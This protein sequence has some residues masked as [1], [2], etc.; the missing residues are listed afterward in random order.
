[1][2]SLN[3]SAWKGG[4]TPVAIPGAVTFNPRF[5]RIATQRRRTMN[6]R[7]FASGIAL[8][9]VSITWVFGAFHYVASLTA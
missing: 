1:M 9:V 7:C 8:F 3:D 6:A 2:C 5:E 4:G